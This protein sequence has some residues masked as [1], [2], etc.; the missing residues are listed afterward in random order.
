MDDE[1]PFATD[2]DTTFSLSDEPSADDSDSG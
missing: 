1:D 2:E